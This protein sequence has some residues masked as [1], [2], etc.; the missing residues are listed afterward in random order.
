VVSVQ[1]E[2]S[3]ECDPRVAEK[4]ICKLIVDNYHQCFLKNRAKV[5]SIYK[6]IYM[7]ARTLRESSYDGVADFKN[8][9]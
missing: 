7:L 5:P 4:N 9:K 1:N 2:N 3:F 8:R 6:C